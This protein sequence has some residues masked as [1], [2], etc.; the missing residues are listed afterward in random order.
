[1]KMG[2]GQAINSP[3]KQ[4]ETGRVGVG[5][6]GREPAVFADEFQ[7]PVVAVTDRQV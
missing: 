1:M 7:L 6:P 3:Q 4:M 2:P 5:P